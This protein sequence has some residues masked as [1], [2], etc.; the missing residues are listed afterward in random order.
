MTAPVRAADKPYATE[1]EEG[2][3]YYCA[4]VGVAAPSFL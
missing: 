2:R 3:T 4:P 1:V